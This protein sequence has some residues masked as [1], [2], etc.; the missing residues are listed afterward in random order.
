MELSGYNVFMIKRSLFPE[1]K[2]HLENPEITLIIGPRQAGKTTLMYQLIDDL[3]KTNKRTLFLS[4][5]NDSDRPYFD[6]QE[7][8]ISKIELEFGSDKGYVFIDEVQ[9]KIDAGLFLKGIYDRNLPYKLIVT[10]SGSVELKEKVHESLAGR[11]RLFEL[12][13]L[14]FTEFVNY[15]TEYRYDQKLSEFFLVDT[16]LTQKYFEEYL[17]YGGYPKVVLAQTEDEKR[18]IIQDIYQ[19]Y[20]EKDIASLLNIQKTENLTNLVRILASQV[21]CMLNVSEMSSTLGISVNTVN[22]YLWY[23]EKT[24]VINK[25]TPFFKNIRKEITKTPVYYFVDLGLKNYAKKQ[26][27]TAFQDLTDGHLFENFV[28]LLLKEKLTPPASLHF[29]RTQDKAEVDFV[30]DTGDKVIPVEVKRTKLNKPEVTRSF[31]SFLSRYHPQ[32]S[33]VVHLGKEFG[34]KIEG[35]SVS[36]I[37]YFLIRI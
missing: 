36:F 17:N 25:V 32:E 19:S 14:S 15:K 7:A 1:I 29:W 18:K 16:G 6:S 23:L 34:R 9:R 35:V 26:F 33:F 28:Y 4:L 21:G 11:K 30:I 37:P 27:G 8:L 24:F 20:L 13:T 10:G 31:R 2:A 22:N 5:D 3:K 12:R